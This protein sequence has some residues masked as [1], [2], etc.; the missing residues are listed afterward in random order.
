MCFRSVGTCRWSG[1]TVS[2]VTRWKPDADKGR[3]RLA[4]CGEFKSVETGGIV[5]PA[6]RPAP[7]HPRERAGVTERVAAA[8]CRPHS[9]SDR[10]I[11]VRAP[12]LLIVTLRTE[13]PGRYRAFVS[14][15]SKL[16]S[17]ST[18]ISQF[19][20]YRV[21]RSCDRDRALGRNDNTTQKEEKERKPHVADYPALA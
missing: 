21:P 18:S 6:F 1:L 14:E 15:N 13:T 7:V 2:V 11:P 16:A 19:Y 20:I 8:V 5:V 9:Y 12:S 17:I 10:R 3:S 4:Y